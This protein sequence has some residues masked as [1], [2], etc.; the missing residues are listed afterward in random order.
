MKKILLLTL[1]IIGIALFFLQRSSNPAL[2]ATV[3]K[4]CAQA[5]YRPSCYEKE[6]PK[7]MNRISME[8]AFAITQ[9]VQDNDPEFLY[10]HV[11]AHDISF[12]E[13]AKHPDGWKD[14]LNRC[15]VAICNYGCLHGSLV[16]RFRG[17]DV[18][19]DEQLEEVLPDLRT[20]CEAR[21]GFTPSEIDRSMC[22]HAL[23][24]LA[25]YISAGDPA[26]ALPICKKVV[27]D[28]DTREFMET[29][30]G[31]VFM[32]VFQG[33]DPED[34]ALVRDIKPTKEN[35]PAFCS[36]Y[37]AYWRQCRM[38]SFAAFRSELETPD[39]YRQFCSFAGNDKETE[40]CVYIVMN[41]LTV[42][43]MTQPGGEKKLA[44]YCMQLPSGVQSLCFA[45]VA[46]RMVQIDPLRYVADAQRFCEIARGYS[47]ESRCFEGI[48]G[49]A[50]FSFAENS[51]NWKTYCESL[52]DPYKHQ[53]LRKE[54]L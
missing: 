40:D 23:G 15:P 10:C 37:G 26:K 19:R 18:L 33:I 51:A 46:M 12:R 32:S 20:V 43:W 36:A 38:E 35:I 30:A 42:R 9:I 27:P 3:L 25:M 2:A 31:G 44:D 45:G 16:Q 22:Y 48:I 21:P 39:G 50:S 54:S 1:I 47:L 17:Q 11:L 53:C 41:E 5:T 4:I 29:C 14:V 13:S 7:L 28:P 52:Q 8:D 24:H 49:Y 6:I 34:I